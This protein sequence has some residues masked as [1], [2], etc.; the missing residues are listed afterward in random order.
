MPLNNK[1]DFV[2]NVDQYLL[3]SLRLEIGYLSQTP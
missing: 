3:S 1:Y 2:I